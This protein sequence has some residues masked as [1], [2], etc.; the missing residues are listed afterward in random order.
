MW[1]FPQLEVQKAGLLILL[2][3]CS[4]LRDTIFI[5]NFERTIYRRKLKLAFE[6][7]LQWINFAKYSNNAYS[8]CLEKYLQVNLC[9]EVI[10]N[11][12]KLKIFRGVLASR[13]S[14]WSFRL[15][16]GFTLLTKSI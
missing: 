4:I 7:L 16:R 10:I 2:Y 15:L 13:W 5:M 14:E 12:E 8:N 3:T 9:A 1:L 11:L 6:N